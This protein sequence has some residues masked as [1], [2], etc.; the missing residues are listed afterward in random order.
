MSAN[1]HYISQ[2]DSCEKRPKSFLHDEMDEFNQIFS[3]LVST[4][5]RKFPCRDPGLLCGGIRPS[6]VI[7]SVL[8]PAVRDES[9]RQL[10]RVKSAPFGFS[11]RELNGTSSSS[12]SDSDACNEDLS[13]VTDV[14][15]C[16][17]DCVQMGSSDD[18]HDQAPCSAFCKTDEMSTGGQNGNSGKETQPLRRH[19][20]DDCS[21]S[22]ASDADSTLTDEQM[23]ELVTLNT[24]QPVSA[25][26]EKVKL[27]EPMKE[28]R[29]FCTV[30]LPINM[31]Q[32]L[33]FVFV[34]WFE[35]S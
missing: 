15:F 20:E 8:K 25:N 4:P 24:L 30:N 31:Q 32:T 34:I 26:V 11:A 7:D 23:K 27:Y 29:F 33:C 13:I 22:F 21:L 3:E 10:L 19:S 9:L 6:H 5:Q 35:L 16:N 1:G 12:V 18:S 17:Q 14:H 2:D 28:V